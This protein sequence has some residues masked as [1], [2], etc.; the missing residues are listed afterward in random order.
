MKEPTMKEVLELVSFRR[1]KDG[2]LYVRN[3]Y[4]NLSNVYGSVVGDVGGSVGGSVG[5]D[6]RGKVFGK[7]LNSL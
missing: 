5:G 3:V 4:G 6:V 1:D 7:I 2:K